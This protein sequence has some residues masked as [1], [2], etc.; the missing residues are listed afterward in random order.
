MCNLEENNLKTPPQKQETARGRLQQRLVAT[1]TN[2][3]IYRDNKG[4]CPR[5]LETVKICKPL[6]T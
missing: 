4:K 1:I 2:Y 6:A 3:Y 5:T